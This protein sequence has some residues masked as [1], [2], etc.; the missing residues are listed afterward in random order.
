M[1]AKSPLSHVLSGY[2]PFLSAT[3]RMGNPRKVASIK[4]PPRPWHWVLQRHCRTLCV[5]YG[6]PT[7]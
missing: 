4:G 5:S 7:N 6:L 2:C 3:S 1:G